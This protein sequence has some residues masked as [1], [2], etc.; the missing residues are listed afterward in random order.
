MV[1]ALQPP[2]STSLLHH[3]PSGG[4]VRFKFARFSRYNYDL[5]PLPLRFGDASSRA[6][7]TITGFPFAD[8][9]T[10]SIQHKTG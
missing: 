8:P 10:H 2:P 4:L 5:T 1:S 6:M 3:I 7:S 9:G